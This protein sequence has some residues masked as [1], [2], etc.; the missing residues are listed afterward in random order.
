MPP[1]KPDPWPPPE[2][3]SADKLFK[4]AFELFLRNLVELIR[5]ELAAQLDLDHARILPP[6]LFSDFRKKG[7]L[8]P[9]LVAEVRTLEDDG[10]QLV[11]VHVDVENQFR[12]SMDGRM[13]DYGLHLVLKTE[14]PVV[15]IAVFLKGGPRGGIEV[16]EVVKKAGGWVSVRFY[17]PAFGLSRCQAEDYVDRPQPLA[18]ALAALM[19][20]R[21][22][23]RVERKLRC[24]RAISRAEGLDVSRRY[25][26]ARIV[27]TYVGL[28]EGE[29]ERFAAELDRESN[30]EVHE[31]VITWEQALAA[32]RAE[33]RSEGKAEAARTA[34][35]RLAKRCLRDVASDFEEKLRAIEDLDRLYEILERVPEVSSTEELGLD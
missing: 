25:V 27:Y 20:S 7:H 14:K 12:E 10:E 9:D 16:R 26:L 11:V 5:P 8:E 4:T 18:A 19:R 21:S 2:E 13:M 22:W 1:K 28:T 33:G 23:D 15:S 34:I 30:K 24:L 6:R 3:T 31:M 32:S 35:M 17:Y 29:E